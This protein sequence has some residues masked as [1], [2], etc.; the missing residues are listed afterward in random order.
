M[1]QTIESVNGIINGFVWGPVM[2][3]LLVG[4]G[5]LLTIRAGFP[6]ILKLGTIMKNT[7]GT[8]FG[9]DAHKKD[10]AGISPYQ[11]VVH[12]FSIDF[13]G[14]NVGMSH[15]LACGKKVCTEC[16]HHRSERVP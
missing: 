4:T 16:E 10:E 15:Q 11:A 7:V 5:I 9:P 6:Q 2:L 8:L 13:R 3:L 12:D 1:V 14:L